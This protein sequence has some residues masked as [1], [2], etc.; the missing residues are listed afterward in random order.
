MGFIVQ[1]MTCFVVTAY[2]YVI[3]KALRGVRVH[4]PYPYVS[5]E[6]Y[7]GS[8]GICKQVAAWG[9]WSMALEGFF[10]ASNMVS[11]SHSSFTYLNVIMQ[12]LM[13]KTCYMIYWE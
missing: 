9:H 4:H 5:K 8:T 7:P 11:Y 12:N 10:E 2:D 3:V 1:K 13:E 6:T